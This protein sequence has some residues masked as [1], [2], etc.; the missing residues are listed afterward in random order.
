MAAV[1]ELGKAIEILRDDPDPDNPQK[2]AQLY[3]K[4]R[5]LAPASPVAFQL[6]SLFDVQTGELLIPPTTPS[7]PPSEDS[8]PSADAVMSPADGPAQAVEHPLPEVMPWEVTDESAAASRS[9]KSHRRYLKPSTS[10]CFPHVRL[11]AEA[12]QR[13]DSRRQTAGPELA[14]DEATFSYR[15]E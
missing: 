7:T 15:D 6:A 1:V 4:I 11:T 2:A 5:E 3:S 13:G 10:R 9:K 8:T 14:S 12:L